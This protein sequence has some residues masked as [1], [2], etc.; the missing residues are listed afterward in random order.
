LGR[1]IETL[2]NEMTSAG[3]H[4]L[5]FDATNLPSG[6]YTAQISANGSHREIKMVLKK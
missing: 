3:S 2:I 4:N 1:K 6:I 5:R